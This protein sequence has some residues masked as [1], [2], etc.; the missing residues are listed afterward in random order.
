ML[1]VIV[2]FLIVWIGVALIYLQLEQNQK[3]C[4]QFLLGHLL[5]SPRKGTTPKPNELIQGLF[6]IF[7]QTAKFELSVAS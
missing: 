7:P 4:W 6:S 3:L 5:L 2:S 1:V